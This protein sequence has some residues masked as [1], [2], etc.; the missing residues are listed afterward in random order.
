MLCQYIQPLSLFC[1]LLFLGCGTN[2]ERNR[3]LEQLQEIINEIKATYAPDSRDDRFDL[4][5]SES[6]SSEYI[7]LQGMTTSQAALDEL[8]E[9]TAEADIT[10]H[11]N[12]KVLPDPALQDSL[13]GVVKVSAANL[14]SKPGHSQE[15]ATQLLLG[16]PL[17]I[18]TRDDNWYLVRAPDNYLAWLDRGAISFMD[19]ETLIQY[20]EQ[21][22]KLY[23]GTHGFAYSATDSNSTRLLDITAG[24]LV[25]YQQSEEGWD[26]ILLPDDRSAFLPTG[27][28]LPAFAWAER[29]AET[30]P[31]NYRHQFLGLPYLWGGTTGKG[32]DC[33]GFTKMCFYL[34]GF[35]IPRD[36]S[37][38]VKAGVAVELDEDL[39]QLQADDLL[40]FGRLRED[41]SHRITHV[42]IYQGEGRFVHSGA[43][44]GHVRE[45][46]L[47]PDS[48]DYAPHRRESLLQARRLEAG[49]PKVIGV[50]DFLRP[51]FYLK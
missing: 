13:Y 11:F 8:L 14:R 42:G 10:I 41:G 17:R 15:L 44:N 45:E 21:D 36:A 32:V 33:S 50:E 48:P 9:R 25:N 40:F 2:Q 7:D 43:D 51:D 16:S 1:C 35:V 47:F 3:Q 26:Q 27:H 38:Q 30:S 49:G 22:L 18:L 24:A 29:S 4:H 31:L 20:L 39:S 5:W 34:N 37:Q 12:G 6:S 19:E 23:L 28:L 46:S